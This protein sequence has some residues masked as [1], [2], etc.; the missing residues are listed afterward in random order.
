MKLAK[1]YA[2]SLKSYDRSKSYDLGEDESKASV[3]INCY[4][5]RYDKS[6][7]ACSLCVKFL[8]KPGPAPPVGST[9]GP[10]GINIPGF[11]KEFNAKTARNQS[12]I[13]VFRRYLVIKRRD[14][15]QTRRTSIYARE[16]TL[17]YVT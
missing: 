4:N 7:L 5:A 11:T 10:H 17:T 13:A 16:R 1:K 9:L 12:D 2:E 3:L 14:A 8:G 6:C 15:S